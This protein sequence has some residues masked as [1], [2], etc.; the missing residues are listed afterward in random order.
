[1]PILTLKE[2]VGGG[3]GW[4]TLYL[5]LFEFCGI[6]WPSSVM[7]LSLVHLSPCL[8]LNKLQNQKIPFAE[9]ASKDS[10]LL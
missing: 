8:K 7:P 9:L 5:D 10:F 3:G 2:S 6:F 4:E 1:M